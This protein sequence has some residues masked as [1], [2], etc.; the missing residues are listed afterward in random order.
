MAILRLTLLA[1]FHG[2]VLADLVGDGSSACADG[3]PD[4]SAFT[5]SGECAYDSTA[6]G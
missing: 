2:F 3:S 1:V 6:C 4:E 5:A